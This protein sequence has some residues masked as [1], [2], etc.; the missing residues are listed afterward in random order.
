MIVALLAIAK[1]GAAYTPLTAE[2]P[3]EHHRYVVEQ[4][5]A[6][7]I[8]TNAELAPVFSACGRAIAIEELAL[9]TYPTVSLGDA[10]DPSSLAYI[11]FTSGSTGAPKG[12]I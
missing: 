6:A 10:W 7:L 11:V 9:E 5:A 1:A 3:Y 8:L 2:Y 12:V 4:T